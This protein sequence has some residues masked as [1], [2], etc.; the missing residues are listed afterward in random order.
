MSPPGATPDPSPRLTLVLGVNQ[1]NSKTNIFRA[2]TDPMTQIADT[3]IAK[4]FEK[5]PPHSIE[6]EMCLL[7]SMMLDKEICGQ[8]VQILDRE[9][10]FRADH[11]VIF[12]VVV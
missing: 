2:G 12:D 3:A 4:Q 11:Q 10:F 9:A 8:I 1:G 6:A 7:A 5:L